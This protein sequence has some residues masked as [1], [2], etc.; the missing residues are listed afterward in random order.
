MARI[1]NVY[2]SYDL[3]ASPRS[4]SN[5]FKFKNC[6]FGATSIIKNSD[7][8]KY[9]HGGF[10]MIFDRP[11]SWSFN[12][13]TAKNVIIC[14]VDNSSS[15]HSDNRKNN[16]LVLGEAAAFGIN[17]SFISS[18]TNFSINFSKSNTK[19]CLSLHYNADDS[20]LFVNGKEIFKFKA[21]NKN[22]N[23]STQFCLGSI[24][25]GFSATESRE[26]SLNG[27]VYDFSVDYNSIDKSDIL[28]IHKYL[29]TKNNIK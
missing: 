1:V 11:G 5:N 23:F 14:G 6:L 2:I 12:Y 22:V 20:Y 16:F 4:P 24:S 3:D 7:K 9:V 27:N 13:D 19:F 15:S 29:M 26:V 21:N 17:G 18:R 25:N 8:E 28:K 10:G